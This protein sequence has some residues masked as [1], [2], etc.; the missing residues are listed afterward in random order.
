MITG[1]FSVYESRALG[2]C[3]DGRL[4]FGKHQQMDDGKSHQERMR[5]P[6]E[7]TYSE[8]RGGPKVK[9][10]KIITI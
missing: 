10:W 9:T 4:R 5:S 3:Q 8:N 7:K 6:R 1:H 2:R